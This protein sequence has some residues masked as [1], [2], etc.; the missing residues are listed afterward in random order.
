MIRWVVENLTIEDRPYKNSRMELMG[1]F[2]VEDL[3]KMSQIPNPQ[4]IYDKSYLANF[5]KKNEEPLKMI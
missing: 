1:S 2:K 4:D 5:A 3:K